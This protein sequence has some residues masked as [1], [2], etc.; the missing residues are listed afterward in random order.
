MYKILIF[1]GALLLA[2]GIAFFYYSA[3]LWNSSLSQRQAVSVENRLWE[4]PDFELVDSEGQ[5]FSRADLQGK[6]WLAAFIFTRCPGPCPVITE[7]MTQVQN[8]LSPEEDAQLVSFT[9]DPEY[10]QPPVL[11]KYAEHWGADTSRWHFLTSEQ[12]EV[13]QQLAEAFKVASVREEDS[14][15]SEIPNITHG[16][17]LLLVGPEGFV[18]AIYRSEDPEVSEQIIEGIRRLAREG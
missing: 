3:G 11:A 9:I 12:P 6:A 18:R 17:N 13:M 16:T 10:D 4:V 14:P 7:K 2:A 15:D 1:V 5:S 8:A